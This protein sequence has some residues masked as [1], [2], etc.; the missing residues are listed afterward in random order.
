MANE[1][2][3][4]GKAG[5]GLGRLIEWLL[6]RRI[7]ANM[8]WLATAAK[9]AP[10][11]AKPDHENLFSKPVAWLLGRQVISA[12]KWILLSAAYQGRLDSR[13]WMKPNPYSFATHKGEEFWFDYLAD[14]GDG[15]KAMYSIAYLCMTD[16]WV[17]GSIDNPPAV[18]STVTL[19]Q[20]DGD[21]HLPRG[22]FLFVG[23][24]TA[25][26]IADY[27]TLAYRF[28]LPFH[29]A[30]N[31]LQI[32]DLRLR[33]PLFGIPGNHDYYDEIEGFHRQFRKPITPEDLPTTEGIGLIPRLPQLRIPTFKRVQEASYVA[34]QLPYN[35]WL[36]G[37]DVEFADLDTRQREF[38]MNLPAASK[39]IVATSRPTTFMGRYMDA[40]DGFAKVFQDLS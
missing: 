20:T 31:D 33:R 9:D 16:L 25:Y 10:F 30:A 18:G 35:W 14:S 34:I 3:P 17:P 11:P 6:H 7:I 24:D 38:F 4:D 13:N 8:I 5:F 29:W 28:Q 19:E 37:L 2:S 39:L 12:M 15:Q 23:G 22:E 32:N 40:D 36:W 27:P 1:S 26:H 21:L